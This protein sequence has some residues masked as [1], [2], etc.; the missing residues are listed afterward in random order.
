MEKGQP[1]MF[2]PPSSGDGQELPPHLSSLARVQQ[3]IDAAVV[4]VRK[5]S[6]QA[7]GESRDE[8]TDAGERLAANLDAMRRAITEFIARGQANLR[9]QE[10][11]FD[12]SKLL[13]S[14]EKWQRRFQDLEAKY[15]NAEEELLLLQEEN[16]RLRAMNEEFAQRV[17][18][19]IEMIEAMLDEDEDDDEE[20]RNYH[21]R[22]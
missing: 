16:I 14:I 7:F 2:Q 13:A 6:Q 19:S 12:E 5:V 11:A 20:Y 9:P 18:H 21:Q 15:A 10:P 17:E 4:G 3:S 1:N 22:P 8:L